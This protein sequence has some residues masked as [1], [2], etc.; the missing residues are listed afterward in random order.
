[1]LRIGLIVLIILGAAP[2]CSCNDNIME[3]VRVID[4]DTLLVKWHG[5]IERMRLCCIDTTESVSPNPESNIIRAGLASGFL[6][7]LAPAGSMIVIQF[8]KNQRDFYGRL[9]GI[10]APIIIMILEAGLSEKGYWKFNGEENEKYNEVFEEAAAQNIDE[11]VAFKQYYY[12]AAYKADIDPDATESDD[13]DKFITGLEFSK[14]FGRELARIIQD[15]YGW[16]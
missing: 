7:E 10:N 8:G 16:R 9:L 1:M 11:V 6:E 14:R 15:H 13:P 5:K 2:Q 4:G 3:V 12:A